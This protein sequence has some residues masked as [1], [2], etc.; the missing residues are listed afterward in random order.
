MKVAEPV[1]ASRLRRLPLAISPDN[2]EPLE[3]YLARVAWTHGI[4]YPVLSDATGLDTN[5]VTSLVSPPAQPYVGR[6][7]WPDRAQRTNGAAIRNASLESSARGRARPAYG[8]PWVR[9]AARGSPAT[10]SSALTTE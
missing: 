1:R 9:S 10:C 6:D 5:Q 8:R 7:V 3:S 2:E 4:A